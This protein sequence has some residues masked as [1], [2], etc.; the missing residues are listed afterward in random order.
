M[1]AKEKRKIIAFGDGGRVISIPKPFVDYHN[2]KPKDEVEIL[3][4]SILIIIPKGAKLSEEKEK[5]L[6]QLLE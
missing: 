6:K 2:L 5:L 1:P 4:D 3:Y